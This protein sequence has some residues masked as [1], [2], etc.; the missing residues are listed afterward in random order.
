[1]KPEFKFRVYS[2][3]PETLLNHV[4][5]ALRE[6]ENIKAY[7]ICAEYFGQKFA[8]LHVDQAIEHYKKYLE[9]EKAAHD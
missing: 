2:Q 4:F 6:G 3:E 1:M 8:Q 7:D 5:Q 9:S